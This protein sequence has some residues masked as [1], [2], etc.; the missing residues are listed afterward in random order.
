[1][2]VMPAQSSRRGR[3]EADGDTQTGDSTTQTTKLEVR[4]GRPGKRSERI[5]RAWAGSERRHESGRRL[6]GA[7]R[8]GTQPERR[9]PGGRP[10]GRLGALAA[11][12]GPGRWTAGTGAADWPARRQPSCFA[13]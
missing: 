3:E 11:L 2:V 4:M 1:M 5:W 12:A 8:R 13:R 10:G 6:G 9:Q 7:T